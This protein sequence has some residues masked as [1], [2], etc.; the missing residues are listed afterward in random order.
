MIN[1][2]D[3][4]QLEIPGMETWSSVYSER[5][6]KLLQNSW[7]GVFRTDV[8][9]LLY[10]EE[11]TKLYSKRMG[12]STKELFSII[13]AVVLQQFFDLTDEETVS[14]LA[15]NQQW[16][17]ALECFNETDQVV[18]TKTLWT[19]RENIVSKNLDKLFFSTATKHFIEKFE[20]DTPNQ[21]IDS[22]HVHS[23]MAR[24]SR[25]KVLVNTLIK[26]LKNLKRKDKELFEKESMKEISEKYLAQTNDSYFGKIKPSETEKKLQTIAND[27]YNIQKLFSH[28]AE[29]TGMSSFK[30][31]VRVFNEHCSV[32]EEIVTVKASK[33][34]SSDSVQNPSDPDAGYS[35]HK[36]QG[37]QTQ[38][39]ET[40]TKKAEDNPSEETK[41]TEKTEDKSSEE[42]QL[43]VITYVETESADKHDSNALPS[44]I[45]HLKEQSIECKNNIADTLY[46]SEKN[47][48]T[49]KEN[50]INLISPVPGKLSEK[51]LELFEFNPETYEII[52]CPTGKEPDKIKHNKKSSITAIWNYEKCQNCIFSDKCPTK[53]SKKGRFIRYYKNS[54]K[55]SIRRKYQESEEFKEEYRYRGGIEATNSR[56]IHMTGARRSRYRGLAKMKFSQTLKALAINVFR[57]TKF[58]KKM[59]KFKN[60]SN[61]LSLFCSFNEFFDGFGQKFRLKYRIS[62]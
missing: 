6:L 14:E 56:F 42:P 57:V 31:L 22:V 23:N 37:Y 54:A 28:K 5:K 8:L 51:G 29:I 4:E 47:V 49:A 41:D 20:V 39:M 34:V 24:L 40:F 58:K 2:K 18:C 25:I 33:E 12:R 1:I 35:G 62:Y 3:R 45:E 9:P 44:A 16:H 19:M 21:R 55:S 15:F 26:F 7:A 61:S 46:G 10:S 30:L 59:R 48:E 13:G 36:G 50:G 11:I 53:E 17:F 32:D 43:N 38:I 27:L 52:S 60:L